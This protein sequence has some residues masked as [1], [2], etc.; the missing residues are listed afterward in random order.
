MIKMIGPLPV[1]VVRLTSIHN[2]A[3]L[4]CSMSDRPWGRY[5]EN[6]LQTDPNNATR[7]VEQ[8]VFCLVHNGAQW[9]EKFACCLYI[10]WIR[11]RMV[12]EP[13]DNCPRENS[14]PA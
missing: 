8:K 13:F 5:L 7:L 9:Q 14:S 1:V 6:C 2:K 11:L 4:C 12:G 10:C 3:P